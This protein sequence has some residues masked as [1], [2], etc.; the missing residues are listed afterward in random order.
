MKEERG[1]I[2]TGLGGKK[3]SGIGGL[4]GREGVWNAWREGRG[5]VGIEGGK[6][7][8]ILTEKEGIE[9]REFR[10]VNRLMFKQ[11]INKKIY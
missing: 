2:E 6:C 1:D 3:G 7:G 10:G 9:A 4:S 11:N 8:G 5:G